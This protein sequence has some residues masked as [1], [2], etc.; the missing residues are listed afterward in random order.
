MAQITVD[1]SRPTRTGWVPLKHLQKGTKPC[2]SRIEVVTFISQPTNVAISGPIQS[3]SILSVALHSLLHNMRTQLSST[4]HLDF[5]C[6]GIRQIIQDIT[7]SNA[8]VRSVIDG[9]PTLIGEKHRQGILSVGDIL[10]A[11]E[12][13]QGRGPDIYG[14]C[15]EIPGWQASFYVGTSWY[16]A[17]RDN[18][19][20]VKPQSRCRTANLIRLLKKLP[21]AAS[22]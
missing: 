21:S 11:D 13:A 6:T 8:A 7:S 10:H 19:Y 16:V 18:K 9:L 2:G 14:N 12:D 3:Q 22:L 15:Y 5:I 17:S 20:E 1:R 4:F